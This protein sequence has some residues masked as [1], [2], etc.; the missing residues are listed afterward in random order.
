MNQFQCEGLYLETCQCGEGCLCCQPK[1][2]T[3]PSCQVKAAWRIENGHVGS[4]SLE[5]L[6]VAAIYDQACVE[7]GCGPGRLLVD[8][9]ATPRQRQALQEIFGGRSQIHPAGMGRLLQSPGEPEYAS[10]AIQEQGGRYTI[11]VN[12]RT[13]GILETAGTAAGGAAMEMEMA[14]EWAGPR[15]FAFASRFRWTG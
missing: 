2:P 4:T 13:E 15:S 6:V 3:R 11:Q 7:P 9:Q 1:G 12:G 8:Q 14:A 5:G 10:L